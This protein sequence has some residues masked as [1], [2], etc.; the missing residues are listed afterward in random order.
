MR[1]LWSSVIAPLLEACRPSVVVEFGGV[2]EDLAEAIAQATHEYGGE[3]HAARQSASELH[4]AGAPD[5]ALIH[6]EPSW[7]AVTERLDRLAGMARAEDSPFALTLIHG[8]D[9]PT[10][11]R[12]GVLTAVEDFVNRGDNGLAL[13]HIP[14][15]G[16]TAL[17]VA[18]EHLENEQADEL[19]KLIEG[20][21]F[22]PQALAQLAAVDAARVRNR[23][24]LVE[25]QSDLEAVRDGMATQASGEAIELRARVNELAAR[26]AVLAEALARREAQLGVPESNG[27]VDVEGSAD[28]SPI[29]QLEANARLDGV[30]EA[31]AP[32]PLDR[33]GI[34]LGPDETVPAQEPE[35]LHAVVRAT[36]SAG[37]LSLCLWS[38]IARSDRKL[39]LTLVT[40]DETTEE[41][42]RLVSAIEAAEPAVNVVEGKMSDDSC[43]RMLVDA[44]VTF[45]HG[46]IHSLF[47]AAAEAPLRPT[48]AVSAGS[49]GT[50]PWAGLDAPAL[51]L[52]GTVHDGPSVADLAASCV[53]L[54]PGVPTGEPELVALGAVVEQPGATRLGSLPMPLRWLDDAFSDEQAL[55]AAIREWVGEPLSVAY[56]LPG[57]PPE[58]SGGSHSIFQEALALRSYGV[59]VRVAV[60]SEFAEDATRLYAAAKDLIVG[61]DSPQ[62]LAAAL[63]G[64]DVVVATE[65]P[66]ARLVDE[67][68]RRHPD[69][70]GA[71]YVQDYE[72]LF[73]P[74]EESRADMA[75]LSY[76]HA[77][78]LLLF[79]KTHWIANVVNAAHCLPVAKVDPSLDTEVFHAG[80]R[81]RGTDTPVRVLAMIRPRTPRRRPLETLRALAR[82]KRLLGYRVECLSFGCSIEQFDQLQERVD[83]QAIEHLGILGREEVAEVLRSC[84]LFLDLSTYQAFGRTGLE[85]M[86][87]GAVPILPGVGGTREFA[88]DG[89]NSLLLD[90][91][92]DE[93]AVVTAVEELIGDPERVARMRAS[94]VEAVRSFSITRAALS[95]YACFATHMATR[96]R[97]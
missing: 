37:Q 60:G 13:V 81:R 1:A 71:Y 51:L 59:P 68:V 72:P 43:W 20:W 44:P 74:G 49:L 93:D 78:D 55:A 11:R 46:A 28:Q 66:S 19:T 36:G 8:V 40:D 24:R 35:W 62:A 70:F 76:R 23:L 90:D 3:V 42:T 63:E 77:E 6:C 85:A 39:R 10:G 31:W 57:L 56:V 91:T 89:S 87:C 65:A 80:D 2:G 17:L 41:I 75:L 29:E 4:T 48:A 26:N 97:S 96:R 9:W 18:K 45:G 69:V 53:I 22:K 52:A 16:G 92:S 7:Y 30:A 25:L 33:R 94:G 47:T 61:Y 95:Q 79:A 27:E 88:V 82:I 73:S 38:L 14:G 34:L 54:P 58:G 5:F 67:H 64:F 15:L 12:H 84:D 50:P 86:A 21:R 32:I 83:P